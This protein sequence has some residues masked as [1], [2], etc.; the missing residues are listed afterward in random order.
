M[1]NEMTPVEDHHG[2]CRD[3]YSNAI[4]NT[5]RDAYLK[6][7]TKKNAMVEQLNMKSQIEELIKRCDFIERQLLELKGINS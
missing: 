7:K 1:T 6:A 3:K 5:N 4:I 2:L